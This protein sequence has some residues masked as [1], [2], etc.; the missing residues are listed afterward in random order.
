MTDLARCVASPRSKTWTDSGE[1]SPNLPRRPSSRRGRP[2]RHPAGLLRPS[3]DAHPGLQLVAL[4]SASALC[5]ASPSGRRRRGRRRAASGA[6]ACTRTR[7]ARRRPCS[8]ALTS[9]ARVAHQAPASRPP[10]SRY[11]GP[12]AGAWPAA[13]GRLMAADPGPR[14]PGRRH[15]RRRCGRAGPRA[16]VPARPASR[17]YGCC[18]ALPCPGLVLG[19]PARRRRQPCRAPA[20]RSVIVTG[21]PCRRPAHRSSAC[22]SSSIIRLVPLFTLALDTAVIVGRRGEDLV[23]RGTPARIAIRDGLGCDGGLR[24]VGRGGLLWPV[25]SAHWPAS[26]SG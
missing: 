19:A 7:G 26:R 3:D 16:S 22:R 6:L 12:L 20:A 4:A 11:G 14:S 2:G 15:A 25:D 21:R 8:S 18:S 23:P 10:A 24:S 13:S 9:S 17:S 1:P 5:A